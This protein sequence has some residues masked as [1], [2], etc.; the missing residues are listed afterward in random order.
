MTTDPRLVGLE[1]TVQGMSSRL[2]SMENRLNSME[3]RMNSMESRMM[4]TIG[5]T[6]IGIMIVGFVAVFVAILLTRP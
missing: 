6:S 3:S 1:G 4:V 5:V 2:S